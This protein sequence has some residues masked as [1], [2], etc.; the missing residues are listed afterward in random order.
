MI[1]SIIIIFAI[2]G[3]LLAFKVQRRFMPVTYYYCT[4]AWQT[5]QSAWTY[6][7]W[8]TTLFDP[9]ANVTISN[10]VTTS[11]AFNKPCAQNCTWSNSVWIEPGL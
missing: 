11:A 3:G 2:T 1:L 8:I 10:A 7:G 5:C 6:G 4:T 9:D